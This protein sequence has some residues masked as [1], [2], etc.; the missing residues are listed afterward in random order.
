MNDPIENLILASQSYSELR[1]RKIKN[2]NVTTAPPLKKRQPHADPY[3]MSKQ[4]EQRTGDTTQF[5]E[6]HMSHNT[7]TNFPIGLVH[8]QFADSSMAS[9]L[10]KPEFSDRLSFNYVTAP[11]RSGMIG[12]S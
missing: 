2:R 4:K 1:L 3:G 11:N 6:R 8:H 10:T 5:K 9:G 7:T 12:F